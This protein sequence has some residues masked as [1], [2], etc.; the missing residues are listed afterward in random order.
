[1]RIIISRCNGGGG[2]P[3]LRRTGGSFFAS[4]VSSLTSSGPDPKHASIGGWDARKAGG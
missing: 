2:Y 3:N 4:F 1:M